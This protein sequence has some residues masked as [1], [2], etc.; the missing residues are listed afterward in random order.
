MKSRRP[1]LL[2]DRPLRGEPLPLDLVNTRWVSTDGPV[3]LFDHP[4]GVAAWLAEHDLAADLTAPASAEQPLRLAREALRA[5]LEAPDDVDAAALLDAVLESGRVQR[6]YAPGGPTTQVVVDP[7][8]RPAWTA[9][10]AYLDLIDALPGRIRSCDGAGC[11]L[12]FADTSRNGRRRWCS[13]QACGARAKSADYYR[14]RTGR[15]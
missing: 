2:P 9:A 13:M 1:D 12:V 4:D 3:D 8:W 10:A 7:A 11:V 15:G 14:R 5:V 6:G